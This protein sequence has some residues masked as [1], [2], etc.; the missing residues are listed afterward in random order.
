MPQIK[1]EQYGLLPLPTLR[2]PPAAEG[3][4]QL[5]ELKEIASRKDD[6]EQRGASVLV[7]SIV[8]LSYFL[9]C[10]CVLV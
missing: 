2:P 10:G 8:I 9:N 4:K 1:K 5:E 6:L 3:G 7:I